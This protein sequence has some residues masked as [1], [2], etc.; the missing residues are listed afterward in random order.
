M[1]KVA[2][3]S[4]WQVKYVNKEEFEPPTMIN[5]SQDASSEGDRLR[6]RIEKKPKVK[7]NKQSVR[8]ILKSANMAADEVDG[9]EDDEEKRG[10]IYRSDES[11]D[12]KMAIQPT[13][14]DDDEKHRRQKSERKDG[15]KKSK[16]QKMAKDIQTTT[17]V[18]P[19]GSEQSE[20]ENEGP[21]QTGYEQNPFSM[22][23]PN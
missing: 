8:K 14:H 21:A 23:P 19:E 16:L 3:F 9:Y 5:S 20:S 7:K 4:F 12:L 6:L 15:K 17:P 11:D 22:S 13:Y 2:F 18:K 10:L 1:T